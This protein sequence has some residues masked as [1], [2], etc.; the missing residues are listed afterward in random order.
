MISVDNEQ[1]NNLPSDSDFTT[2][3]Y[4][5]LIKLAK[6]RYEFSNY[7]NIPWGSRFVLW[8]HDCD[9]SLNRAY[10]LA[11]IEFEEGVES[12]FFLNPHCEFYNLFEVHQYKIIKDILDMGHHIGL[13]FDSMFYGE[14]NQNNLS[15]SILKEADILENLLGVR[16][17]AFSFHNPTDFHM[18]CEEDFYGGLLNCYSKRFKTEVSYCSDSNGY[19]RFQNLHDVLS[20]AADS[21]LQVLT[22][23][24]WWQNVPM[25][26]RNRIFR[27]IYGRAN[28]LIDNYDKTL[29]KH[30]RENLRGVS[31]NLTFLKLIDSERYKLL[32]QLW[33]SGNFELLFLELYRLTQVQIL[34][35]CKIFIYKKWAIQIEDIDNFFKTISKNFN[36]IEIFFDLIGKELYKD[37]DIKKSD[38]EKLTSIQNSLMSD[39]KIH[40]LQVLEAGSVSL[41]RLIE[42]LAAWGNENIGFDG[43][44]NLPEDLINKET[45]ANQA[46]IKFWS[47]FKTKIQSG[48]FKKK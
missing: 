38:F 29:E 43:I 20:Q 8:R 31:S 28:N 45:V 4:R 15:E 19:W 17:K 34:N 33:M 7:E 14:I 10:V 37:L 13:H 9:Y 42:K 18:E 41:C 36:V 12:T 47:Q 44:E 24:G 22:H 46:S 23:P 2:L 3:N 30:G 48:E 35:L 16:P 6:L 1:L 25:P 39:F 27:A 40:E 21:S 11:L 32:D 5:K 26:P